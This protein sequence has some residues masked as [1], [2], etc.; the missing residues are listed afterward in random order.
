VDASNAYTESFWVAETTR[1]DATSGS[2]YSSPSSSSVCQATAIFDGSGPLDDAALRSA[3]PPNV[4]TDDGAPAGGALVG[5]VG[6]DKTGAE[7]TVDAGAEVTLTPGDVVGGE[8][9][10]SCCPHDV[11]TTAAATAAV[12]NSNPGR[13]TAQC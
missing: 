8:L 2:P 13:R 7:A 10:A 6:P 12:N 5:V 3:E 11:A 9:E 4:V 1:P